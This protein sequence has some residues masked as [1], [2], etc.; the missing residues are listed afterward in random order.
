MGRR[1]ASGGGGPHGLAQAHGPV[2][3]H[4]SPLRFTAGGQ[5][6]DGTSRHL[7]VVGE[8]ESLM[9]HVWSNLA[10]CIRR[11]IPAGSYQPRTIQPSRLGASFPI[12][13][14]APWLDG[15]RCGEE[16]G[17]ASSLSS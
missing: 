6:A 14:E 3:D 8:S 13:V 10:A 15:L 16:A 12:V 4:D 2:E 17:A 11:L 5:V 9:P 7:R 1:A